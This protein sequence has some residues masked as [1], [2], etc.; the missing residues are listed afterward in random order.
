MNV[1]VFSPGDKVFVRDIKYLREHRNEPP[2]IVGGMLEYAGKECTIKG[3]S[4]GNGVTAYYS[5]E[6]YGCLWRE[7][8]FEPVSACITQEMQT[9]IDSMF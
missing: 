4:G 1:A 8:W 5:I 3:V 7:N 6:E 9:D 2:T